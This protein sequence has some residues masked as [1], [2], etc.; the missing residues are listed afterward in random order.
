MYLLIE[1]DNGTD[2]RSPYGEF[3]GQFDNVV[4]ALNAF[5]SMDR[6][7]GYHLIL[8]KLVTVSLVAV[9]NGDVKGE[10]E[11]VPF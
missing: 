11:Y 3:K 7:R 10:V 1:V 9:E 2:K 5:R 6:V 8:V 4:D